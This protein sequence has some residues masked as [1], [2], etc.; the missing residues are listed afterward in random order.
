MKKIPTQEEFIDL[1]KQLDRSELDIL[2]Y[3][4]KCT[5]V[6][7]RKHIDKALKLID[8]LRHKQATIQDIAEIEAVIESEGYSV[9]EEL[10]KVLA[11]NSR[12]SIPG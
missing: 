4:M 7:E 6:A 3:L 8:E 12:N 10:E 9:D 11:D 2:M 5:I 1:L